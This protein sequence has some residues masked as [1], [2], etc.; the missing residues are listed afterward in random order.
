L[1]EKYCNDPIPEVAETCELALNRLK[2]LKFNNIEVLQRNP[3]STIDPA[4]P[5]EITDVC[6]LKEILLDENK[7]LFDRYRAMFSLRNLATTDSI[8]VLIEG[9]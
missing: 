7:S 4:P 2:W 3:Y 8:L 5:A 9:N 6:I 1:L